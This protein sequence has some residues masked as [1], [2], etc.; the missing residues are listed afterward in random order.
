MVL[1]QEAEEKEQNVNPPETATAKS[2]ITTNA[3]ADGLETASGADH[4]AAGNGSIQEQGQ[5]IP[6]RSESSQGASEK[7]E[8]GQVQFWL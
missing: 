1:I 4:G 5:G 2:S 6:R 3:G 7:E 8:L